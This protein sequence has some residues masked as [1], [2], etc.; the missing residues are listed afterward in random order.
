MRIREIIQDL[1]ELRREPGR[2]P[3]IPVA[4]ALA[5]EIDRAGGSQFG[6]S[7]FLNLFVHMSEIVK[8]GF[9]PRADYGETP[10]SA[11]P[12]AIYAYPAEY[13]QNL[14]RGDRDLGEL[15]YGGDRT[16]AHVFA[17]RGDQGFPALIDLQNLTEDQVRSLIQKGGYDL[18]GIRDFG[19]SPGLRFWQ[20]TRE[21]ARAQSR[22]Q[23][24]PG[25]RQIAPI[26]LRWREI[27]KNMGV[28]AVID[29][30]GVIFSG[31][32][33]QAL[34]LYPGDLDQTAL[35]HNRWDPAT[36]AART[37]LGQ[38][39]QQQRQSRTWDQEQEEQRQIIATGDLDQID[40][41]LAR[42][43]RQ[44][45]RVI[46]GFLRKIKDP[47]VLTRIIG[48]VPTL[49]SR[50]DRVTPQLVL[51]VLEELG[52][53][54]V[55]AGYLWRSVDRKWLRSPQL[56]SELTKLLIAQ[57]RSGWQQQALEYL[58]KRFQGVDGQGYPGLSDR[59]RNQALAQLQGQ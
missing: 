55:S 4:Q 53:D 11:T 5:R 18:D 6:G 34:F 33:L 22:D 59:L 17:Y 47:T 9:N 25:I 35:I 41:W 50:V 16:Y 32:D 40:G 58:T 38:Q 28:R 15:P 45:P 24:R 51:G 13:A 52:R 49:M 12:A 30:R 42:N 43:R 56:Y 26:S 36:R 14:T 2:N 39:Q 19:G 3:R 57:P 8:L 27:L 21:L 20:Y 48:R 10:D 46:R 23:R 1:D 54:P 31:E 29:R 44:D 37:E 7:E